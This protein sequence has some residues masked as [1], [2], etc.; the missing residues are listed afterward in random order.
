MCVM[1]LYLQTKMKRTL[2]CALAILC[3]LVSCSFAA[4]DKQ[5]EAVRKEKLVVILLDG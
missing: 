2:W 1:T 4:P 5:K 3:C